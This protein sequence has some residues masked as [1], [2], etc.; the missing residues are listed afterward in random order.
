MGGREGL[1]RIFRNRDLLGA[2]SRRNSTP[3]RSPPLLW[4]DPKYL[5]AVVLH[6][7]DQLERELAALAVIAPG[8]VWENI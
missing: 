1:E 7:P 6:F 4:N 8:V 5:G 3:L 2:R